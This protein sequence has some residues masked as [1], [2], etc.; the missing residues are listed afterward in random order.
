MSLNPSAYIHVQR[1]VKEDGMVWY[2]VESSMI[3][4]VGYDADKRILDVA[5]IPGINKQKRATLP[6]TALLAGPTGG[7][8]VV[9]MVS[10][11]VPSLTV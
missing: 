8:A 3:R 9:T 1:A 4:V 11:P 7:R 5:F 2:G 6:R 10:L